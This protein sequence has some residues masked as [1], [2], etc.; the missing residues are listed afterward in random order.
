MKSDRLP[1]PILFS[2]AAPFCKG[3]ASNWK[4]KPLRDARLSALNKQSGSE[5]DCSRSARAIALSLARAPAEAVICDWD[6]RERAKRA[7]GMVLRTSSRSLYGRGEKQKRRDEE[8]LYVRP[9]RLRLGPIRFI[10]RCTLIRDDLCA[11]ARMCRGTRGR[12]EAA[13]VNA[14]PWRSWSVVAE[15][16]SFLC[17]RL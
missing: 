7:R 1:F 8:T 6:I 13:S 12:D 16:E 3:N 11:R 5:R 10:Q 17:L 14:H 9:L 2:I 15:S 4:V